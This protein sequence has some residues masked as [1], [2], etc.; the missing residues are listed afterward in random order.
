MDGTPRDP[1]VDAL[2]GLVRDGTL[3][4]AQA[5]R[6]DQRLRAAGV[7]GGGDAPR[8][9]TAAEVLTYLGG[10]LTVGALALVVGLSWGELGRTGQILV[11]G[12]IT[13]L[14]LGLA[15]A[16]GMWRGSLFQQ[17]R[18]AVASVLA[19][20]GSIGAA[21]TTG[22][23]TD[24]ALPAG[25]AWAPVVVGAVVAVTG[26]GAYLAWRGA[27]SVL[28]VFAGGLA[29]VA[30][31][32]D[33]LPVDEVGVTG[34][35]VCYAYGALWVAGGRLMRDPNPAGVLGGLVATGAA[36]YLAVEEPW[37]GLG[38]GLVAVAGMFALF[39]LSRRWWYAALGVLGALVVPST[40]V[41]ALWSGALAAAVL[42]AVGVLLV[43]AALV[44]ARRRRT[45]S[46][47]PSTAPPR[48]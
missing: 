9:A 27:P 46:A 11:C 17:R 4:D 21:L 37:L 33:L 13:V 45:V 42:L 35:L 48:A 29:I 14:F 34:G 28:V 20:L 26:A 2:S 47:A 32:L 31:L 15:V 3:T 41:G 25:S 36:E 38:L 43:A 24:L 23:V 7:T 30:G 39:W 19:A 18:R 40:A 5:A 6:V 22:L 8:T 12:A 1:L 44:L 10:A 16:V